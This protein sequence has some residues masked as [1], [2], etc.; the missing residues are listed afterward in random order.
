MPILILLM[1]VLIP[2]ASLVIR[3]ILSVTW[4]IFHLT[5]QTITNEIDEYRQNHRNESAN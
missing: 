1:M 5:T 4:L 3:V 2:L